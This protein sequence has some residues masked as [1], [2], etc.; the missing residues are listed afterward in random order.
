MIND[1]SGYAGS[2]PT[3]ARA[4]YRQAPA[5]AV[6]H[7]QAAA[8]YAGLTPLPAS[9]SALPVVGDSASGSSLSLSLSFKF[10]NLRFKLPV[11]EFRRQLL[12]ASL[13]PP[14]RDSEF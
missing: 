4:R 2:R 7:C 3:Q 12:V 9:E 10:Y 1:D 11:C 8:Y 6:R 13:Y 14:G 5:V